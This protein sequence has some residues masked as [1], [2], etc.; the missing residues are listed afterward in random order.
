MPG[1]ADG[2]GPTYLVWSQKSQTDTTVATTNATG[3]AQLR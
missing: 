1:W 3:P 2:T